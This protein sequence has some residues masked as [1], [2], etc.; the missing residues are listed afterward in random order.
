MTVT[1]LALRGLRYYWRTNLAVVA[2]RR[3]HAVEREER[4][5]DAVDGNVGGPA[6]VGAVRREAIQGD[7]AGGSGPLREVR[8]QSLAEEAGRR[9]E[10]LRPAQP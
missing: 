1:A 10:R 8:C 5:V 2:G 7:E 9:H 3:R 6:R 4:I